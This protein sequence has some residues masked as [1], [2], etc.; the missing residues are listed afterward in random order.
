MKWTQKILI[1]PE[2]W[3]SIEKL[4]LEDKWKILE[5]IYHYYATWEIKHNWYIEAIFWFM[6][7]RIDHDK[8]MYDAKCKKNKDISDKYR[9]DKKSNR[10]VTEW[11][12]NDIPENPK[13]KSNSNISKDIEG[14]KQLNKE[15][16]EEENSTPL[17]REMMECVE[18]WYE[19][20]W[21]FK[22]WYTE[23]GKLSKR[24]R[25]AIN[26]YV[27]NN[28]HWHPLMWEFK[29]EVFSWYTH[30]TEKKT[31]IKDF[32]RSLTTRLKNYLAYK[33]K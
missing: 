30:H 6:K 33:Q 16:R 28:D 24:F 12:P 19:M 5:N 32:K 10:S 21:E 3:D 17:K 7:N 18:Y 31:V 9:K 2:W 29:R 13:S 11:I 15:Y 26:N 27:W 22:W 14:L 20:G 25:E 23:L 1:Y 8:E 4:S